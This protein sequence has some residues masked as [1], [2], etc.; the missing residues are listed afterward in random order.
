MMNEIGTRQIT[1]MPQ[2]L[3]RAPRRRLLVSEFHQCLRRYG[4]RERLA[5]V[6]RGGRASTSRGHRKSERLDLLHPRRRWRR[7]I[8]LE[9]PTILLGFLYSYCPALADWHLSPRRRG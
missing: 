9:L 7:T 1:Y 6:G 2:T 8:W 4:R 5:N 3:C